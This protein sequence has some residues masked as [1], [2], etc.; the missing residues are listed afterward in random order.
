[1]ASA[2]SKTRGG[3][4]WAR[5]G[6][7]VLGSGVAAIGSYALTLGDPQPMRDL[8]A[9]ATLVF[10]GICVIIDMWM[11]RRIRR[12]GGV[13]AI[14]TGIGTG[15]KAA[16]SR[17][18]IQAEGLR[19]VQRFDDSHKHYREAISLLR[20]A[21]DPQGVGLA[22]LGQG[23]VYEG[24][25]QYDQAQRAYADAQQRFVEAK[26]DRSQIRSLLLQG[27]AQVRQNAFENA[28]GFYDQAREMALKQADRYSEA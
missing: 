11:S 16:G 27:R 10:G 17:F 5:R 21:K 3:G 4:A 8:V 20:E 28:K 14:R 12:S 6:L 9:Q 25:A 15:P 7:I 1:M 13:Q 18:W 19:F 26:D 22:L 24:Q 2:L 23:E